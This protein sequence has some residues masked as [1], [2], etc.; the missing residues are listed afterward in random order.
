MQFAAD[1]ERRAAATD[2]WLSSLLGTQPGVAL[3]AVG[4]YGRREMLPGSDLD[5]LL[6]HDGRPGIAEVADRIWYPIWDRGQRLDHAVRTPGQV[7]AA[8]AGDI[9]VA[10]GLLQARHVAGEAALTRALRLRLLANWRAGI[11]ERLADLQA[12][13]DERARR[14]GELAFLLEPDLKESRGGLRDALTIWATAAAWVAPGPGPRVRAAYDLLLDVRHALHVV[15]GRATDRLVMQEQDEVARTVGAD[16]ADGLMQEIAGAGRTIAYAVDNSLRQAR[17][18]CGEPGGPAP[19]RAAGMRSAPGRVIQPGPGETAA[20][21]ARVALP[22]PPRRPLADGVVEQDGE[23]VLARSARPETDP[24]L[25]LRAAA[26]AAQAGLALAPATLARL[27]CCPPLPVPWPA[28]ARHALVALLG[29]GPPAITVWEAL[30]QEGLL[31]R[32]L[33][34]WERVRNR[35]QRNPLHTFSVDRHLV[36]S[37]VHAAALSRMVSR[38]DLLLITALLHDIGKGWPGDHRLTGE[39]VARAIACRIGLPGPDADMVA[40]LVRHHLLLAGT[41]GQRDLADPVTI[42]SVAEMVRSASMLDLLHALTIADA[43][44]TGPAAWSDWK[45]GLVAD[46]VLRVRAVL[47]GDPP[48]APPRPRPDQ[49]A[50]AGAGVPGAMVIGDEVTVTAPD[51]PGLLWRA[52]AVL[53][54]HRLI[55]RSATAASVGTMAVTAFTVMPRFGDPPDPVVL[56]A[57]LR[58]VLAGETEPGALA[59]RDARQSQQGRPARAHWQ[60]PPPSVSLLEGASD[61][62][63]V[64]EV[65]THDEAGLLWRIARALEAC[66][67]DVRTARVETLGAEAVDV[68]YV[69]DGTGRPVQG[70]EIRG[71]IT[72]GILSAITGQPGGVAVTG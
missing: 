62:A 30:D 2:R 58:R 37:A 40:A 38:P 56:T 16:G 70:P 5:V 71:R 21:L 35:P 55:I 18:N 43:R 4:G 45:A 39:V 14:G 47:G 51:R 50:L 10:L 57:D 53:D 48:P 60:A 59:G 54:S 28:E 22:G 32:L 64:V 27:A 1:R 19:R 61:T 29:A 24:V 15:T 52:A 65:R 6:L 66:G 34:D 26:A 8:A 63:T 41:A 31:A 11:R 49:V 17:R 20:G 42:D 44:A 3:I 36:E 13:H 69:V 7:L 72:A 23:A 46:L 68:F 12:L 33:P 25:P 67:L 9:R